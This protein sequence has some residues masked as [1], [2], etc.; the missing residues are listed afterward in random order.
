MCADG[1]YDF[2]H[3]NSL[4]LEC[5]YSQ[6]Q[7]MTIADVA[8]VT[9][10][11][12]YCDIRELFIGL[13][14]W[15]YV[16]SKLEAQKLI[17]IPVP[18]TLAASDL[19][20]LSSEVCT[21]ED[22]ESVAYVAVDGI[23][24]H[25][26]SSVCEGLAATNDGTEEFAN[27]EISTD[28]IYV[29][30]LLIFVDS[31]ALDEFEV[32][33]SD[34]PDLMT[35]AYDSTG[36][37][38]V[39]CAGPDSVQGL[40]EYQKQAIETDVEVVCNSNGRFVRIQLLGSPRA[41]VL[42][43]VEFYT[44]TFEDA[45]FSDTVGFESIVAAT[46]DDR[47]SP[48]DNEF[49]SQ[50]VECVVQ[51]ESFEQFDDSQKATFC[52][53]NY[54]E[55]NDLLEYG[56][57]MYEGHSISSASSVLAIGDVVSV[58]CEDGYWPYDTIDS[59]HY[60]AYD[61][62]GLGTWLTS[63]FEPF[64]VTCEPPMGFFNYSGLVCAPIQCEPTDLLDGLWAA[65]N[66]FAVSS[67]DTYQRSTAPT[68][69]PTNLSQFVY[70]ICDPN[71]H[72]MTDTSASSPSYECITPFSYI[73]EIVGFNDTDRVKTGFEC[74][75]IECAISDLLS[76]HWRAG[77][78]TSPVS[79]SPLF[80]RSSNSVMGLLQ[81][82]EI[83]CDEE[84][85]YFA[86]GDPSPQVTC[87]HTDPY[88]TDYGNERREFWCGHSVSCEPADLLTGT[89]A[90]GYSANYDTTVYL[91]SVVS[92]V[93]DTENGYSMTSGPSSGALEFECASS[94]SFTTLSPAER[95]SLICAQ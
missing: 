25:N 82:D 56:A 4:E 21:D 47:F 13:W 59:A 88:F 77:Y 16:A 85:G 94:V 3:A 83:T 1:Y 7:N 74:E 52:T 24:A 40:T 89:W 54:C 43:E 12:M 22:G 23:T 30:S 72:R 38:H 57:P 15:G 28:S 8:S 41:L 36:G 34:D 84:N 55:V 80:D 37:S 70:I 76:D 53:I 32:W 29:H 68:M 10:E 18:V 46:C 69:P 92:I 49:P 93:C 81:V 44:G 50:V 45:A 26:E 73:A 79:L 91:G 31:V 14:E 17:Q 65:E 64:L 19:V 20:I 33:I 58:T 27:F 39:V 2:Q 48:I 66:G 51:F 42:R 87:T 62:F 11:A 75:P 78:S 71:T 90:T 63:Q 60:H 35:T 61:D 95:N 9:C 86:L 6:L 67:G 5:D